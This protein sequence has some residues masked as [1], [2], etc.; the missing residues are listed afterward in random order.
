MAEEER[1]YIGDK[2]EDAIS[3]GLDALEDMTP[4][5]DEYIATVNCTCSLGDLWVNV[6]KTECEYND[7]QAQREHEENMARHEREE[8]KQSNIIQIIQL[9]ATTGTAAGLGIAKLMASKRMF[10][11]TLYVENVQ[12]KTLLNRNCQSLFGN[13]WRGF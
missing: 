4:G 8:K 13:I 2:V 6:K 7:R 11:T 3:N 10:N 5:S 9:V 1:G 12:D